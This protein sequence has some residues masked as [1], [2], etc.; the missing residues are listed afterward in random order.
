MEKRKTQRT[1]LTDEKIIPPEE[2]DCFYS[3]V[4]F[5]KKKSGSFH[6]NSQIKFDRIV[7]QNQFCESTL[8]EIYPFSQTFTL[9]HSENLAVLGDFSLSFTASSHITCHPYLF[10]SHVFPI[11]AIA[12]AFFFSSSSAFIFCFSSSVRVLVIVIDCSLF[13]EP[14]FMVIFIFFVSNHSILIFFSKLSHEITSLVPSIESSFTSCRAIFRVYSLLSP[15]SSDESISIFG[16]GT[17]TKGAEMTQIHIGSMN[18]MI[19]N[20]H[21]HVLYHLRG[22]FIKRML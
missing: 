10:F 3:I 17:S 13:T 18:T 20:T 7:A 8:H 11:R 22:L 1:R 15:A 4:T 21:H 6:V 19:I 9:F 12:S 16:S 2:G 5:F 14:F